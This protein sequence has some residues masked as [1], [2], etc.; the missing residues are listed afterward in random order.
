[1]ARTFRYRYVDFGTT[2]SGDP[3]TRGL[4]SGNEA[5]ETL[6]ANELATDVGGT[7]W[8]VNEPLAIIDHHFLRETRFPSASA[9]V[10]HTASQIRERF[11]DQELVWLVT[12]RE[13]NFDAFCSMYLARW[14]IDNPFPAIDWEQYG[15]RSDGSLDRSDGKVDR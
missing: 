2:F 8:G 7:C 10:L 13:P 3:R 1:M 12:H 4:R 5:P 11:G 14:I 15:L 6:F 9:A